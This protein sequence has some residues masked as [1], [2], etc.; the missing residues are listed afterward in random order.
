MFRKLLLA[1][2]LLASPA[3][4]QTTYPTPTFKDVITSND[5]RYYGAK[6]DGSDSTAAF[7]NALTNAPECVTVPATVNGFTINGTIN[8]VKCLRG[9]TPTINAPFNGWS[10][11]S[12]LVCNNQAAQS[13]VNLNGLSKRGGFLS[14]LTITGTQGSAP[15]DSSVGVQWTAGQNLNITNVQIVNFGSCAKFG[16]S[17]AN[18]IEPISVHTYNM[19]L[20]QCHKHYLVNDGTPEVYIHGGRWGVTGD[21][22]TADDY[23][24]S[25]KTASAGGGGGPNSLVIDSVQINGGSPGCMFRWGGFTATGGVTGANK[26]SNSHIEVQSSVYTGGA[27]RGFFCTDSTIS[28]VPEIQVS[29]SDFADDGTKNMPVW[30]FNAATQWGNSSLMLFTNNKFDVAATTLNVNHEL[31]SMGPIIR[32]NW[33]FSPVTFNAGDLSATAQISDNIFWGGYTISGQWNRLKLSNNTGTMADT[34]TGYVF[35]S[36]DFPRSWTPTLAFGSTGGTGIVYS[37]QNGL[38]QR[39][40]GGG[41][42]ATAGIALTS[43]GAS[44]GTAEIRGVPYGCA[45]MPV[46]TTFTYSNLAGLTGTPLAQ[47][48]GSGAQKSYLTQATATVNSPLTDANFTD[49]SS[50]SAVIDCG[51]TQ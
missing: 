41:F 17:N 29:N 38:I 8:V 27:T 16:P 35:A 46:T 34:A 48:A 39:T 19:M 51:I 49:T 50:V 32:G 30:N 43:K 45:S 3:M 18:G 42:H 40:P 12:Y 37:I 24:F 20:G 21:Y 22:N 11:G 36:G 26:I 13:C 15:S 28:L 14:D 10:G 44:P 47:T 5:V 4:A 33:F 23:V 1:S 7:N 9:T 31:Y 6:A 2:T 25:T